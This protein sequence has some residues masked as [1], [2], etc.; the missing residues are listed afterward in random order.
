MILTETYLDEMCEALRITPSSDLKAELLD[1]YGT[2]PDEY[3]RWS[4]QDIY[5]QVRKKLIQE[6]KQ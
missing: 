5:E 2:D 3:H 1:N 4:E 6:P